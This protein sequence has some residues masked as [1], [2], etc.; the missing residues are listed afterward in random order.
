[1]HC[2]L[3]TDALLSCCTWYTG[4]AGVADWTF[5]TCSS[6]RHNEDISLYAKL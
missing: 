2:S 1:M 4:E 6:Y 3:Q 5:Y